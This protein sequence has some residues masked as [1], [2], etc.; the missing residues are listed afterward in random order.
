V[1]VIPEDGEVLVH[2]TGGGEQEVLQVAVVGGGEDDG[3]AGFEQVEAV[4]KE[5]AGIVDVLDDLG[6][7]DDVDGA[8]SR[9]EVGVE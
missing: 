1:T 8:D 5:A 3:A 2:F 6:G 7:E 9:E 4:A